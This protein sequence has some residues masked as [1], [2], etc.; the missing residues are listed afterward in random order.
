MLYW[1]QGFRQT[2]CKRLVMA[3]VCSIASIASDPK[4][5]LKTYATISLVVKKQPQ[6]GAQHFQYGFDPPDAQS[7][8]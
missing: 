2:Y 3:W 8:L 4:V 7:R 5:S 1:M 6:H